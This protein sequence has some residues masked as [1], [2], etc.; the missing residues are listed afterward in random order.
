MNPALYQS[1]LYAGFCHAMLE[2]LGDVIPCATANHIAV[3][4]SGGADSLLLSLFTQHY[5]QENFAG[6]YQLH[7]VIIDHNLREEAKIEAQQTRAFLA[8]HNINAE[9]ITLQQRDSLS[10]PSHNI[11][12]WARFWRYQALQEYCVQHDILFLL[13][14]HHAGDVTEGFW[15]NL[16]RGS[17]LYGLAQMQQVRITDNL[18]MIRP[19]L[20][21]D[22]KQIR[23]LLQQCQ[24]PYINDVSND[25]VEFTRNRIRKSMPQWQM[26]GYDE[27]R[28]EQTAK[29][30]RDARQAIELQITALTAEYCH[31]HPLQFTVIDTA[32]F[33][34]SQAHPSLAMKIL[35]SAIAKLGTQ[36]AGEFYPPR[37]Q[38]LQRI[39]QRIMAGERLRGAHISKVN[40]W[41][42]ED[43]LFLMPIFDKMTAITDVFTSGN[44]PHFLCY[45]NSGRKQMIG[46]DWHLS[47][48]GDKGIKQLTQSLAIKSTFPRALLKQL[49]AWYHHDRLKLLPFLS[50][51]LVE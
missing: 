2:T 34:D 19:L 4:C 29:H 33:S 48:L 23:K 47:W 20:A 8:E 50:P 17:G 35:A 51:V 22:G 44:T 36:Q 11:Q 40:L 14:G 6:N 49:P 5:L 27:Q 38:K 3:A 13:L 46:E 43:K 31:Y 1:G 42:H 21:L 32:L 25:S 41:H 45:D 28:I 18:R 37:Y 30:L 12:H 26:E 9:I 16:M 10:T 15:L 39:Y 24:I 7:I